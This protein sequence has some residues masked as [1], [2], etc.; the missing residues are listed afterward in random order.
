MPMGRH[1]FE[2]SGFFRQSERK[3]V[4]QRGETKRLEWNAALQERNMQEAMGKGQ[5]AHQCICEQFEELLHRAG[6]L[7]NEGK[8]EAASVL[9]QKALCLEPENIELRQFISRLDARIN[10]QAMAAKRESKYQDANK[11][12]P[13]VDKEQNSLQLTAADRDHLLARPRGRVHADY[14][15][16]PNPQ[17]YASELRQQVAEAAQAKKERRR[18][19][20]EEEK[21]E[22]DVQRQLQAREEHKRRVNGGNDKLAWQREMAAQAEQQRMERRM[23]YMLDQMPAAE[24]V[25]NPLLGQGQLDKMR[26]DARG[27]RDVSGFEGYRGLDKKP[28]QA[29]SQA[30]GSGSPSILNQDEVAAYHKVRGH[31]DRH[32]RQYQGG[33]IHAQQPDTADRRRPAS[34]P[35]STHHHSSHTPGSMRTQ[36]APQSGAALQQQQAGGQGQQGHDFYRLSVKPGPQMGPRPMRPRSAAYAYDGV[37]ASIQ[38]AHEEPMRQQRYGQVKPR[39]PAGAPPGAPFG[40]DHFVPEIRKGADLSPRAVRERQA[41]FVEK[42]KKKPVVERIGNRYVSPKNYKRPVDKFQIEAEG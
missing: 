19:E 34:A 8:L 22:V 4:Q 7:K 31:N 12:T 28:F 11:G 15:V 33:P 41:R 24:T 42:H 32:L 17:Q 10:A 21:L 9:C 5:P 40:A 14:R 16:Q 6:R 13:L 37:R 1:P 3:A 23:K 2:G 30:P 35:R 20:Q 36:A 26:Q 25:G 38:D 29:W 27:P 18:I 39:R